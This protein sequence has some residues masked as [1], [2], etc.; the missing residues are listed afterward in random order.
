MD[1]ELTDRQQAILNLIKQFKTDKGLPPTVREIAAMAGISA[2]TVQEHLRALERKGVVKR[3]A[4]STRNLVV[5]ETA[6]EASGKGGRGPGIERLLQELGENLELPI[7]GEIAAGTPILAEENIVGTFSLRNFFFKAKNVFV[8]RVRGDSMI[9]DGIFDGDYVFVRQQHTAA[10]GEIVAAMVWGEAT[11]KRYYPEGKSV[12][13]QPANPLHSP[14]FV[15]A[16]D[17]DF[18]IIGKVTRVFRELE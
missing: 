12:R 13:L 15:T 17:P 3:N 10:P 14:I 1:A 2:G 4:L 16:E 8:L 18:R 5:L 11:V 7:I 9:E 6:R